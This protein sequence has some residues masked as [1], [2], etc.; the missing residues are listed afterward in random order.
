LYVDWLSA[1]V[2]GSYVTSRSRGAL[3]NPCVEEWLVAGGTVSDNRFPSGSYVIP[4]VL[5]ECVA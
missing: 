1:P 4:Y 5:L 2:G 3:E